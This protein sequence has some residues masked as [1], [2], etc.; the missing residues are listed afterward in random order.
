MTRSDIYCEVL[1]LDQELRAARS[2]L[3]DAQ[4]RARVTGIKLPAPEY[5]AAWD[6]IHRLER[7][8]ETTRLQLST[9]EETAAERFVTIVRA[10]YPETFASV[11]GRAGVE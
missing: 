3:K 8:V 4:M 1:R 6:H 9:A 10:E 5:A 11:S 2:L 7:T